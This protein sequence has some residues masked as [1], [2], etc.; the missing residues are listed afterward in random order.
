MRQLKISQQITTRDT[1]SL[2]K[3][4]TEISSI[5]MISAEEEVRLARLAKAGDESAV[6][7]LARANLRFV[8]SV[9]KQYQSSGEL[10]SDLISAGN[11]GVLE[12]AR[13][14]DETKGFKFISYAVWWIRQA[15][16][17]YIAENG[18]V[19]RIPSNKILTSNK[20]KNISS[21]LEQILERKPTIAEISETYEEKFE[22]EISESLVYEILH[23]TSKPA[24]MDAQI[25]NSDDS[26]TMHELISGEGLEDM[27]KKI[28]QS[29]LTTTILQV[30][31]R[32][33]STEK[34]V[35]LSYYGINCEEKSLHEI[36]E[37]LCL[38]RERVR[39]IKEKCIRKL[40][41]HSSRKL[42]K[43][44]M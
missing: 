33:S 7:T 10:L 9:A 19:I 30:S 38:T 1:Q 43:E 31:E 6:E 36:G 23:C 25:S 14:F 34:Y 40:K 42:L 37:H 24:S 41:T 4:F 18:K 29:D 22:D 2:N 21:E 44:Y 5:P 16:T 32:L 8:V 12:A 39:Q 35:L 20:L 28:A 3:Y 17:Q 13:R 26:G 11:I 15:I 27:S